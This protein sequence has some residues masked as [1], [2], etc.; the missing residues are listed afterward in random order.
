VSISAFQ[1]QFARDRTVLSYFYMFGGLIVIAALAHLIGLRAER[2]G[3]RYWVWFL[4]ALPFGPIG[5]V[6]AFLLL[7]VSIRD[8][9]P[10]VL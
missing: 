4:L 8:Q 10:R 6:L 9:K 3:R 7:E 2:H 1:E 5:T